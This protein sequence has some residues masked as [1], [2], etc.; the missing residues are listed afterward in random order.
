M[1]S[2]ELNNGMKIPIIGAG[3]FPYKRE[4]I[5]AV[6][7]MMKAGFRLFD[8]SDNYLNEQYLGES[9]SHL[10]VE[11][12]NSLTIVTKYSNPYKRV[13]DAF[14]E[15]CE[16]IYRQTSIPNRHP[17]IYLMHWPYPYLW[18]RRWKEM[19]Q[20]VFNGECKAIGVCNFTKKYLEQL[21]SI[22]RVRPV[23]NQLEHHPMFQQIETVRLCERENIQVM[24]YSPLA[25]M[26]EKLFNNKTLNRIASNHD[27]TVG[28]IIL[29][30]N[31]SKGRIP[32]PASKS[33]SHINENF[34]S[35][36]F[37]LT[38][39]ELMDIDSLECGM[40]IRYSPDTRFSFRQKVG[41]YKQYIQLMLKL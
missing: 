8:T 6:P 36:N 25:R 14:V 38:N 11:E 41:F 16:K 39:E 3:T 2:I 13:K 7:Q 22:C 9:I 37:K 31:I 5:T 15:S 26:N 4:L 24:S 17:D 33:E 1:K 40:R 12:L 30:W 32:I 28:Q 19:E 23:I 29:N 34:S 21:L 27:K 10:S 20:L 18:K 35:I